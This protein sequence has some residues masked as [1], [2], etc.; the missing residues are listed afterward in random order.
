VPLAGRT[1]VERVLRWLQ[2]Q[3]ASDVVLNLHARPHTVAASIGDGAHLGLRVRYSWEQP[4]L[5]SAGGPRRALP[6]LDSDVFV[7]V[8]GDTLCEIDLA[9]MI[10]RHLNSGA[11]VTL[12]VIP[13]PAPDRYNIVQID[14]ADRVTGVVPKGTATAGWHFVGIQVVNADVFA[15]L[16]D[17]EP[18]ETVA[19]I[20]RPLWTDHVGSVGGWRIDQPFLDVG[21]PREY[22]HA[23]LDLSTQGDG[24]A[25]EAGSLIDPSAQLTRSVVWADATIGAGAELSDCIVVAGA[26]VP[27]GFRAENAVLL[28]ASFARDGDRVT[29][30]GGLAVFPLSP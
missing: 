13:N 3:G 28:P 26:S 15:S 20:Y 19:G 25:C 1:L 24:N 11:A 30:T 21:A 7:I 17:G 23:A 14:D 18:A 5:G 9:P 27:A 6:L 29:Q 8:N 16:P 12:G 22:L 10:A 2:A 4:L